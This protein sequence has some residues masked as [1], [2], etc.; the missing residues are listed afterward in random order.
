MDY[1]II[2]PDQ[3]PAKIVISIAAIEEF[4]GRWTALKNLAPDRL[5]RLKKVASIASIGSSTRIEG[6]TLSNEQ[7]EVLLSSIDRHSFSSR[8]EEEVAGYAEAMNMVF[9]HYEDITIT[10]NHIRQLHRVLLKYSSKDIHHAGEYKKL[11]NSVEA[12]DSSGRSVG[13]VF[14]TATPFLTP[15]YMTTLIAWYDQSIKNPTHHPLLIIG[16]FIVHFLAIHPFQD[17]NGRLSRILTTLLLLRHGYAYVPY[18]SLESIVE[19][20]KESYYR[21]LRRA[22]GSFKTDH[23]RLNDWLIFFFSILAKQQDILNAKIT[24]ESTLS[25]A[26]LPAESV[27]ILAIAGD[28]GR[29]T[30]SEIMTL[31]GAKRNT[32]KTR[33]KRLVAEKFLAQHGAGKGAWYSR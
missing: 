33:L 12:F 25:L 3:I 28:R 23:S 5:L 9:D 14:E 13:T 18:C 21:A 24:D 6:V 8:D 17:G 20:N 27:K 16:T 30:I 32:V 15:F 31:T 2:L 29:I 22:Q 10:E 19:E 11:S 4:R 7:I 26:G 1:Q